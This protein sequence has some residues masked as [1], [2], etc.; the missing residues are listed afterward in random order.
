MNSLRRFFFHV[1]HA[2]P[3]RKA[4]RSL[5]KRARSGHVE[6]Y[7]VLVANYIDF[8]WSILGAS[9]HEDFHLRHA[10]V[11]KVFIALWQHLPFAERL[12]D[13]S[14]ICWPAHCWKISQNQVASHHP[15]PLLLSFAFSLQKPSRINR[16]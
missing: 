13:F 15:K 16:L 12:S 11:E 2:N 5:L 1:T 7:L 10:R 4:N 3:E 9:T 6:S 8:P 14:S